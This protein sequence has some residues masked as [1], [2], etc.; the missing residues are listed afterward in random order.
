MAGA[1]G[2]WVNN[3]L[4]RLA[5]ELTSILIESL[6]RAEFSRERLDMHMLL[7]LSKKIY[8]DRLLF[9]DL[10]D[11]AP[12]HSL[13]R[14]ASGARGDDVEIVHDEAIEYLYKVLGRPLTLA[15]NL[16]DKPTN[17]HQLFKLFCHGA[18]EADG[19]S[20]AEIR[21]ELDVQE[22]AEPAHLHVASLLATQCTALGQGYSEISSRRRTQY[23]P[24]YLF[25]GKSVI[26]MPEQMSLFDVLEALPKPLDFNAAQKRSLQNQLNRLLKSLNE[27]YMLLRSCGLNP[28]VWL[29]RDQ[30]SIARL[31]DMKQLQKHAQAALREGRDQDVATA[32]EHAFLAL[33]GAKK[34]FAGWTSFSDL[35]LDEAGAALVRLPQFSFDDAEELGLVPAA[36]ES[37]S[38]PLVAADHVESLI[39]LRPD[40]FDS[41]MAYFFRHAVALKRDMGDLLLDPQFRTL[42][43]DDPGYAGYKDDALVSALRGKAA[44]IVAE[45][46]QA[47]LPQTVVSL[48]ESRGNR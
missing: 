21:R 17:M 7:T 25:V 26:E 48:H 34:K 38:D 43:S 11:A 27:R 41:S 45:G 30:P 31:R 12:V 3:I 16:L 18:A 19:W 39:R 6:T 44:H 22:H 32:C 37:E 13:H 40:L 9:R 33:K 29:E 8:V 23:G 42:L 28:S 1:T 36:S 46:V 5:W 35:V 2:F 14:L 10:S 24:L 4:D 15:Q 20:E 47:Y